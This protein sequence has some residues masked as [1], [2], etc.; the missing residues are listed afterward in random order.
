MASGAGNG[1]EDQR[2]KT[3]AFTEL[4][5]CFVETGDQRLKQKFRMLTVLSAFKQNGAKERGRGTD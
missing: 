4:S 5:F 3:P 2:N 1:T